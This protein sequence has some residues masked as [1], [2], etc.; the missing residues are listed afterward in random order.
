[1]PS[2]I[3]SFMITGESSLPLT[4]TL[5][6]RP[7]FQS[8]AVTLARDFRSSFPRPKTTMASAGAPESGGSWSTKMRLARAIVS[9]EISRQY[10]S[11][12]VDPTQRIG[13]FQGSVGISQVKAMPISKGN[14][15]SAGVLSQS[16]NPQLN[17]VQDVIGRVHKAASSKDKLYFSAGMR[18][19][20][21]FVL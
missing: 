4:K 10:S 14:M 5:G 19:A 20:T 6:A 2:A 15:T 18:S 13:C 16:K 21:A 7:V 8:C 17:R 11:N 12:T 1:M 3:R 9:G